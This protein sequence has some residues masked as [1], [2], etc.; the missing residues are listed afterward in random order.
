MKS[1]MRWRLAGSVIGAAMVGSTVAYSQGFT[2][3]APARIAFLMFADIHDGGWTQAFEEARVRMEPALNTK[4]PYVENI[5][6][7]AGKIKP[8]AEPFIGP[9]YNIILATA[10]GYSPPSKTL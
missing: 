5:P 4:I 6:E 2:L 10:S 8:A 7:V 9:R 3:S 1:F